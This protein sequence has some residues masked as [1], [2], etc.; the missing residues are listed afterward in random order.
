MFGQLVTIMF[1]NPLYPPLQYDS[2]SLQGLFNLPT[3]GQPRH[4]SDI[5]E[6]PL[7]TL[8]RIEGCMEDSCL[9]VS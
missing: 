2:L 3:I 1:F 9:S 8:D 4:I 6:R 7:A 5:S